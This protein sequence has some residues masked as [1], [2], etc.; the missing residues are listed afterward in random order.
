[1]KL[2]VQYKKGF[3]VLPNNSF[4]S[5]L[6]TFKSDSLNHVYK[7]SSLFNQGYCIHEVLNIYS[8]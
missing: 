2:S 1:M 8:R 6:L 4:K 7:E 5:I 3:S